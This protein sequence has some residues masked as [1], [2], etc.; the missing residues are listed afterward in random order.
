MRVISRWFIHLRL[1]MCLWYKFGHSVGG[2]GFKIRL[3]KKFLVLSTTVK[4]ERLT[5][6]NPR[7]EYTF[8]MSYWHHP[9]CLSCILMTNHF[10]DLGSASDKMK[11]FF[12]QSEALPRSG[13]RY[14]ISIEFLRS[15]L[16]CHF[17]EKPVMASQYQLFCQ[18]KLIQNWLE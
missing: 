3:W 2:D 7:L 16:R 11:Q 15:F 12:N 5:L 1:F 13:Q 17:G 4:N 10:P 14:I 18:T 8:L 6:C 9:T